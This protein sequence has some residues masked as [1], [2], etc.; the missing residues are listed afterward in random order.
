LIEAL[1]EKKERE[2]ASEVGMERSGM[3]RSKSERIMVKMVR[4]T[5]SAEGRTKRYSE[6]GYGRGD[7][8]EYSETILLLFAPARGLLNYIFFF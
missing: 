6:G 1:A 5:S 2:G 8:Q 4:S 7:E 3:S